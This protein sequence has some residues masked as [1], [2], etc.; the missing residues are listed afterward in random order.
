MAEAR[1]A[2]SSRRPR[3]DRPRAPRGRCRRGARSCRGPA[4]SP[5]AGA[6]RPSRRRACRRASARSHG[7]LSATSV[8]RVRRRARPSAARRCRPPCATS[9]ERGRRRGARGSRCRRR[10]ACRR[11]ARA[12]AGCVERAVA[13]GPSREPVPPLPIDLAHGAVE[14]GDDD[15][16]DGRCRSR[17]AGRS[18]ASARTLPGKQQRRRPPAVASAADV[19][20]AAVEQAR[21]VELRDH[22]AD[23]RR[24]TA[25]SGNSPSCLPITLPAGSTNISVGQ[26]RTAYACQTRKSRS[27]TTGWPD[28]Q[29]QDRLAHG[30]RCPAR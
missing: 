10:R 27:L 12:P 14:V 20:R 15:P 8:R 29:A 25:R 5:R 9:P 17:R 23:Q 4:A 2:G 3:A 26:A 11:R 24:R 6:C 1:S 13:A 21:G 22:L 28:V 18:A 19:E 7:E 30:S 16:V